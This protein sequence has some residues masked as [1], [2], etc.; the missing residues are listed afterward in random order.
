MIVLTRQ[1][2]ESLH[3][4]DNVKVTVLDVQEHG[5]R[6]GISAP[7]QSPAYWEQTIFTNP[8]NNSVQNESECLLEQDFQI[9]C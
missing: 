2:N 5:V 1:Q 9:Q 7:D 4:G 6:L 8:E 3:I